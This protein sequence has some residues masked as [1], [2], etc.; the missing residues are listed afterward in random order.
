MRKK[1][2]FVVLLIQTF[3]SRHKKYILIGNIIGFFCTL[4]FLQAFPLIYSQLFGQK[5]YVIGIV[6]NFSENNLPLFIQNQISRGITS[7]LP[8]G[9]ATPLLAYKWDMDD[10]GTIY[11][12]YL[13]NN[14]FWHDG[15]KLKA[16]DVNY[17]FKGVN[18]SYVDDYTFK[19]SL[20]EPYSPITVILSKPL[21][22]NNL[23]G[24]GDYKVAKI[25]YNGESI[26]EI[27]LQ[28]ITKGYSA[29]KY[30]IYFSNDDAL[31][32]FK[33]GEVNMLYQLNS[34]GNLVNW[35]NIKKNEVTLYDRYVGIFYNLKS[36]LFKE[37]ETRQGLTYAIPKFDNF[38]NTL[39]PISP[40]S[41]AYSNKTRLYKYDPEI[42]SKIL[43][44]SQISS[45]SS[46]ITISAYPSL[47]T[48][49]QI[50]SEAWKKVG[51]NSKIKVI[52]SI[53]TD[54]QV[55]IITQT[56]P[57][58]PDQ[59]QYWQS[60]QDSTNLTHY[61]NLKID[62]LLEDGRKTNDLEK[63]KKIYADF[64]RYL[65]DDAPVIFLYYPKVYTVERK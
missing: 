1:I 55:L 64:Q 34:L 17:K 21:F 39:T 43:S 46:E 62:K 48:V 36:D 6:G 29:I 30:R 9:E 41:W 35:K 60:T 19:V 5:N 33:R 47:L 26:S 31:L 37:K 12:F 61:N 28:P 52:S 8:S 2:L 38:E 27:S 57:P 13:K 53:P 50:V 59:Y 63:R 3:T 44:K 23:I 16:R 40:F 42:A 15:S 58:D 10:K 25:E 49:A 18:I 22:K 24:N 20:K 11:T 7:L 32:G 14:I 65:V 56:I 54:F 45:A 4:F 51:V